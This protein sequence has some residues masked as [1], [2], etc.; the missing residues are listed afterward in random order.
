VNDGVV[1]PLTQAIGRAAAPQTAAQKA[2]E[3]FFD[4]HV[5]R[6]LI[7]CV[8]MQSEFVGLG[9]ADRAIEEEVNEML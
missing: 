3:A 6:T 8:E 2:P 4:P 7:A 5:A 9:F 1:N